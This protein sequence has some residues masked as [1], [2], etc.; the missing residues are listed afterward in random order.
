MKNYTLAIGSAITGLLAG[1]YLQQANSK[2]PESNHAEGRKFV[3]EKSLDPSALPYT[4]ARIIMG[5]L[6]VP[7]QMA[8]VVE[9]KA[10]TF[11]ISAKNV[12]LEEEHYEN[13]PTGFRFASLTGESFSPPIPLIRYPLTVGE[14]W[15][16]TGTAGL[17]PNLK[18]AT[19]TLT[20]SNDTLN[21]AT[22]MADCV[23]ISVDL[24]VATGGPGQSKRPL[25]FWFEPGK[26]IVKREFAYSSTREPRPKG[27]TEP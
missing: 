15:Q 5:G 2:A 10:V 25:K 18:Q 24:V 23:R 7:A 14:E 19:A 6:E 13:E 3:D 11:Q 16:W 17:G 1:C 8:R 9:G 4:E 27:S 22:G 12:V 21:L 20:S 26:G